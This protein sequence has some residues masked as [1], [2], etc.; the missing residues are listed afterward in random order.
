MSFRA[1]AHFASNFAAVLLAALCA[2][3]PLA[4]AAPLTT[5]IPT[6]LAAEIPVRVAHGPKRE[7][8]ASAANHVMRFDGTV[9]ASVLVSGPIRRLEW[10]G[11]K[12]WVA[13]HGSF[14]YVE[15]DATGR[16]NYVDLLPNFAD[17]L[18][19]RI[20]DEIWHM[21]IRPDGV[22]FAA[23][24]DLFHVDLTGKPLRYWHNPKRF[25]SIGVLKGDLF[26]HWR[27]EGLK[28]LRGDQ[29]ELMPGT[30]TMPASV[31]LGMIDARGRL[32]A[33]VLAGRTMGA[34][35]L[36]DG[37]LGESVNRHALGGGTAAGDCFTRR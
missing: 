27:G 30:Q 23:L 3:L 2:L 20:V 17:K 22:Y 16:M 6:P 34:C 35:A 4:T 33:H 26:I 8:Y 24:R 13:A 15:T 18:G 25:G 11:D 21:R 19:G 14:G 12:L 37:A 28:A 29:W 7:I 10:A 31:V 9:W 32:T 36:M 1:L 5:T